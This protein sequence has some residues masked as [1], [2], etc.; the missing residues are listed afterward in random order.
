[1][2]GRWQKRLTLNGLPVSPR[3]SAN[4]ARAWAGVLAPMPMEP[5]APALDTAAARAGVET[6]T[7]G[8]WMMGCWIP[9]NRVM[10]MRLQLHDAGNLVNLS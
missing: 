7:M 10:D 6:P 9:S 5:R 4:M 1:M 8:A 2:A 3:V